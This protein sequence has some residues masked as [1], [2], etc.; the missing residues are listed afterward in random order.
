MP[1]WLLK[2]DDDILM[3]VDAALEVIDANPAAQLMYATR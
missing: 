1:N 2:G 3:N